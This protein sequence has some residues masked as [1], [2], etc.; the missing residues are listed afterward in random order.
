M[1]KIEEIVL[2]KMQTLSTEQQQSVLQFIDQISSTE[3]SF[4]EWESVTETTEL[5]K[6]PNLLQQ[7]D[8]A[9]AEYQ[10]GDTLGMEQMFG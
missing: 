10:K 5:M 3:V 2:V 8:N 7:I 6:I 1:T 9:R 4:Q